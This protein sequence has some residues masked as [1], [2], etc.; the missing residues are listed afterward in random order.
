MAMPTRVQSQKSM[1]EG[2]LTPARRRL[3]A[4]AHSER[5]DDRRE[6]RHAADD[7]RVHRHLTDLVEGQHA[8]QH[9]GDRRDRVGLEQVRRHAGAVAHVVAH[10]VGD[11]GRVARVVL[12]DPSLDFP[13]E[14]GAHVGGLGEDAA[15]QAGEHRYERATEAEADERVDRVLLVG[16]GHHQQAV[17]AGHTEQR[18][19]GHQQTGH[20]A[21]LEG[22]FERGRHALAGGLGHAGVGAHRHVHP[23]ES[24]RAG[25]DAA[26]HEPDRGLH[27]QRDRDRHREHHRHRGDDPVLAG[28]VGTS[29]VLDGLR[30]LLHL[31]VAGRFGQQPA[32][33]GNAVN[34]G[35]A[36][37]GERDDHAPVGKEVCQ[38]ECPPL[39]RSGG[40]VHDGAG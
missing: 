30:D 38:R 25:E 33:G 8:E 39:S 27:V 14:V 2:G 23:D 16:A 12:R 11:H 22:H 28:Q 3:G 24:G 37:A 19:S 29:A 10:V 21:T 31:L 40:L 4:A 7:Q 5:A 36:G 18:Q 1:P 6:Q 34:H 15:A 32:S 17:V 26:D 13:N 20:G 9:H 35:S